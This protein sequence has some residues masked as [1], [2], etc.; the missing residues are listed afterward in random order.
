MFEK[1]STEKS[2]SVSRPSKSRPKTEY[3]AESPLAANHQTPRSTSFIDRSPTNRS[4]VILETAST[5]PAITHEK[6]KLASSP[7]KGIGIISPV[8]S[9]TSSKSSPTWEN[10]LLSPM[11]SMEQKKSENQELEQNK[12]NM[13]HILRS[14]DSSNYQIEDSVETNLYLFRGKKRLISRKVYFRSNTLNHYLPFHL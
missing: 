7:R 11:P 12:M 10:C 6:P 9:T 14:A 13:T 8:S 3:D 1:S 5:P 4:P 2:V